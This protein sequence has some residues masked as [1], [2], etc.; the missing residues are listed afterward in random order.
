VK[1]VAW[2]MLVLAILGIPLAFYLI[3]R[4]RGP[5]GRDDAFVDVLEC[6][7]IVAICGRVLGWW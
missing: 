6:A 3:G 2:A 1:I 7:L 4:P 5:K